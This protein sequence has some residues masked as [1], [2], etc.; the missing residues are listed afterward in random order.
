M[1]NI[2]SQSNEI[3]ENAPK[4]IPK[5]TFDQLSQN[6]SKSIC[7][8]D[9][10]NE[11]GT[12]AIYKIEK[13]S[14]IC[15][16]IT[17]FHVLSPEY[18]FDAIIKFEGFDRFK[19]KP[20]W[21]GHTSFR[22]KG[23]GDYLAIELKPAGVKFLEDKG[24]LFLNVNSARFDDQIVVI[25]YADANFKNSEMSV[26]VGAIQTTDELIS[27]GFALEYYAATGP[28]TSGSP[29]V[30][31]SGE[32][33]GIHRSREEKRA[34]SKAVLKSAGSRRFATSLAEIKK[35]ILLDIGKI[36]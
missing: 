9:G 13:I 8:I 34:A 22:P 4:P 28:G 3:L 11:I 6:L 16:I 27:K 14:K 24:L 36:N 15:C 7:F 29:L 2:N 18:L 33:I 26:G 23:E 1:G 35:N 31:W 21:V 5:K 10:K 30:L 20:E 12:G 17:C 32:A 19:F 25:G